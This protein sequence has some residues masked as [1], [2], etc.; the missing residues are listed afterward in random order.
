MLSPGHGTRMAIDDE[1]RKAIAGLVRAYIAR[2]HIS[3]ETFARRA[4]IGK[5][6]VDKLVTGIASEKTIM[7]IEEQ[8][9]IKLRPSGSRANAATAGVAAA[10]E[11]GGYSLADA[12]KYVGAYVLIRPSFTGERLI[13]AFAMDIRWDDAVPALAVAQRPADGKPKAQFG[14]IMM[15]RGAMHV[16]VVANEGGWASQAILSSLG[17]SQSMKGL[18][19]TMGNVFGNVF[20]PVAAPI[21]LLKVPEVMADM[22]G[23]I[24]PAHARFSVYEEEIAS[25]ERAKYGTWIRGALG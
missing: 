6:T 21:V 5:S 11:Y 4:K 20:S 7:Q 17:P 23:T 12:E 10:A 15:P 18:L 1:D 9:K 3:R 13:Y 25:I 22:C 19:L 8:L 16:F 24:D 14:H 2:E